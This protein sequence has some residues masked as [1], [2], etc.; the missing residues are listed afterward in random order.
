MKKYGYMV[1]F[2][3][4]HMIIIILVVSFDLELSMEIYNFSI[5]M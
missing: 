2:T 4:M 1:L 3:D 5:N